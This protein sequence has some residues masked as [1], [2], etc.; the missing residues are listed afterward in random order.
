MSIH[1]LRAVSLTRSR[2]PTLQVQAPAAASIQSKAR[3][4]ANDGRDAV[5][6]R[7]RA[8]AADAQPGQAL[9]VLVR[10]HADRFRSIGAKAVG[11]APHKDAERLTGLRVGGIGALALVDRPFD[12]ALSGLLSPSTG[13]WSTAAAGA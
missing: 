10:R 12:R 13:Y 2:T 1:E 3:A 7:Q 5:D 6:Q 8:D 4:A 11:M 9:G